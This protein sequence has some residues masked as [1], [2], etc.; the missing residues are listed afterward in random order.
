MNHDGAV[1]L[2]VLAGIFQLK[3]LRH[4]EV[5]LNGAALPRPSQ[6]V[7]QME[8]QLRAIEGSIAGV[9]DERL[10]HLSDGGL[11]GVL[12]KLP[13]LLVAHVVLRHGGELNLVG[14][15]KGGV[16][17]VKELHHVLDLILHLLRRHEDMCV[18]LC[19][20]PDPEQTME[21][22]GHLVAVD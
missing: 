20:A 15:A 18:I 7:R 1:L 9:D 22:P 16:N 19:E 12:R 4:L 17:L 11:E 14:Q 5:Q 13:V 21:C 2:P 3:A 10:P 6:G 8:V